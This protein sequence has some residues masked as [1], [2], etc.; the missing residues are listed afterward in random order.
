M[1]CFIS[2]YFRVKTPANNLPNDHIAVAL[3]K[4]FFI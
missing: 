4:P 1:T 2:V 3:L